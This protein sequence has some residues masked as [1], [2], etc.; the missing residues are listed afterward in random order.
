[1]THPRHT[2]N[3]TRIRRSY[4]AVV[5]GASFGGMEALTKILS[6]LEEDFPAPILVVQH[7]D[8]QADDFLAHYLNN[9]CQIRVKIAEEKENLAPGVAYLAPANYHLLVEDDHTLSLSVEEKVNFS[10]PSIDVLF[11]SA[12]DAY[13]SHLIGLILTGA[14][15]D[16]SHGLRM[17]KECG[18]MALVQ[19]PCT[20]QASSMPEAALLS[21]SVDF[22]LPLDELGNCLT[23]I[24]SPDQTKTS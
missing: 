13:G 16:G 23:A 15:H 1:M 18:G 22:V 8:P 5:I 3:V 4:D 12:A 9:R 20:A 2:L 19:D 7:Q 10:R 6:V 17:I 14:N 11:E 21:T 24:F